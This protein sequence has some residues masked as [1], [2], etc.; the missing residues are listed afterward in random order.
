MPQTL[1]QLTPDLIPAKMGIPEYWVSN[2][3][4]NILIVFRDPVDGKYQSR[5]ELTTG[6]H[7]RNY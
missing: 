1:Q 3:K 7:D 4:K 6:T 5:R 2:L